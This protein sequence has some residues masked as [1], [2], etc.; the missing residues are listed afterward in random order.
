MPDLIE[1]TS[2]S[3][4]IARIERCWHHTPAQAR[5]ECEV[6][7]Q[8]AREQRDP[9]SQIYAA[10]LYGKI[11]DHEGKA[12]EARNLL[13]EAIQQAQAIHNFPLEARIHEQIARSH[14]SVGDYRTALQN[15]LRCIELSELAHSEPTIWMLAKVGLGQIYDALGDPETA[16]IFHQAAAE[17]SNEVN[18][19]YLDAKIQ[20]NLGVNLQKCDR[21]TEA[22]KALNRA[23]TICLQHNYHDYTAESYFRLSEVAIQQGE[24]DQAMSQLEQA[25]LFARKV[26]YRW[27]E[28]NIFNAMAE[29]YALRQDWLKAIETLHHGQDISIQNDFSHI[30][31]RQHIAA[32]SYAERMFNLPL[33]LAELKAGFEFQQKLNASS[34]PNQRK[35]LEQQTGL[36]SSVSN[37]IIDLANHPAIEEG[38]FSNFPSIICQAASQI[39]EVARVGFWQ[40]DEQS[41]QLRCICL[42]D[43]ASSRS[44][45]EAPLR[46]TDMPI[47]FNWLSQHKSLIAH[48]ALHHPDAW[49]LTEHYLHQHGVQSVLAF[50]IHSDFGRHIMMFEHIG[51]QRNWL[52]DDIQHAS[53]VTDIASRALANHE[54]HAFQNEIHVLN[55]KLLDT[56]DA[57]EARVLERTQALAQ[58]NQDL[59][60]AMNKLVQSEKLAALGGLVAGI[61][62][63]LNTPLGAALTCSTTLSAE[64]KELS[65]HLQNN[66]L[67]KSIL[68]SFVAT[69]I[70][71]SQLIERNLHRASELV[72]D[73]KQVAVDTTSARRR[74]FDLFETVDDV[75]NMLHSQMR[76]T[77]HQLQ[78]NIPNGIMMDSFPGAFEQVIA[79]LI[80]NSLLHGFEH[81][82]EGQ[83]SLT[84]SP[85]GADKVT[86]IYEDNGCGI[87]SELQRRVFD[88]FYTTKLGQGG[89]GLG[90]YI[91]YNL[92]TGVLGGEL[93]LESVA[94]QYTRFM[95][96][97]PLVA[98]QTSSEPS[99]AS[100]PT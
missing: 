82:K 78:I 10:E 84:V 26:N 72:S 92:I 42:F 5:A 53:Q 16:V 81:K 49:D 46:P 1:S 25:L 15:W 79:N 65:M 31:M 9:L 85:D 90:L 34:Q 100:L 43:Q 69:S 93:N 18:D 7:I 94:G 80:N 96:K 88:P 38:E 22:T 3:Q 56:N 47:F 40:L 50:P 71:A 73:F 14:Y 67:K 77:Q 60:Q 21:S 55:A 27:G 29:I 99:D 19:P 66:T 51:E 75:V 45:I 62:H 91:T 87:P 76:H 12:L 39:L 41:Q 4:E 97:L 68:E 58:S 59:H 33:A 6:L 44:Q 36:R 86:L 37:M 24:L 98:P 83:M 89:S 13:Y 8:Q 30:L 52:P 54:R 61:A 74:T 64:S 57:L 2:F 35:E 20:I 17:R 48:D 28:A 95:I 63:E 32:A 11:M 70:S 23:L